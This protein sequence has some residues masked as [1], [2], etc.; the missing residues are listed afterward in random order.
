MKKNLALSGITALIFSI[1]ALTTPVVAASMPQ[2]TAAPA[3]NN[4]V[5]VSVSGA[6]PFATIILFE[7]QSSAN[8][9]E[10]SN[11]AKTDSLGNHNDILPI[12]WDGSSNPI[13]AYVVVDG[14]QSSTVQV[15][16]NG[17]N[18]INPGGGSLSF[19]Q[20]SV[21]IGVGQSAPINVYSTNNGSGIFG[22][23]NSNSSVASYAISGNLIT[24]SGISTGSTVMTFCQSFNSAC[25]SINVTVNGN[26]IIGGNLVLNPSSLSLVIGQTSAVF[27]SNT[28]GGLYISNNSN[29]SIAGATAN[30]SS[31][32][33]S[34]NNIGSDN[35]SICQI[36]FSS[37]ANLFVSVSSNNGGGSGGTITFNIT[38]PT[39]FV[40][41]GQAV[42]I[43]PSNGFSGN[44]FISSNSNPN[45][46][47]A[48]IGGSTLYLVA[49]NS[50]SAVIN[51]CQTGISNCGSL[52]VFV[53]GTR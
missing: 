37:C 12:A 48:G 30:G 20:N 6:D 36:G 46:V 39:M 34:G 33:I 53:N 52:T 50:G 5:T 22:S 3:S 14:A 42:T 43:N 32:N 13:Q 28:S 45:V 8:W 11:W 17:I 29:P 26:G 10:I 19:S 41:Q 1:F 2:L 40:G 25:G 38:N 35:I 18:P 24:I 31:V 15:S 51:V 27:S 47:S 9:I 7:R 49:N 44:Y 16:S 21:N 23:S 4:T